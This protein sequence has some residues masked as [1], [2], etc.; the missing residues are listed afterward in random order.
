MTGSFH[1][2]FLCLLPSAFA[3]SLSLPNVSVRIS[4]L[5][6]CLTV[7][8][9]N[10][11]ISLCPNLCVQLFQPSINLNTNSLPISS[12]R[13]SCPLLFPSQTGRC[14]TAEEFRLYS[15]INN[16]R[17]SLSLPA[18]PL[19]ATLTTVAQSHAFDSHTNSPSNGVCNLHS[20]SNRCADWTGVCY[21]GGPGSAQ[22]MWRKPREFNSGF[23]QDGYEISAWFSAGQNAALAMGQWLRSP[24]HEAILSQRGQW[25]PFASVGV[26]IHGNFAHAWFSNGYEGRGL[27]TC[28]IW[29][30]S[31]MLSTLLNEMRRS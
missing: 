20:W 29:I 11:Q 6:S 5:I 26:G 13:P 24:S 15:L 7:C 4:D 12:L 9:S 28:W 25:G 19:S 14:L 31:G 17:R 10:P 16:H 8:S 1:L 18:L 2:L 22:A 3:L 21:T 27:G 23:A 30:S